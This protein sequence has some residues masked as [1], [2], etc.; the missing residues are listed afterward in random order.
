MS[1]VIHA[2]LQMHSHFKTPQ[3]PENFHTSGLEESVAL[4]KFQF[5]RPSQRMICFVFLPISL[6][7]CNSFSF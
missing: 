1:N 6:R 7:H 3:R 5:V 2:G 4:M